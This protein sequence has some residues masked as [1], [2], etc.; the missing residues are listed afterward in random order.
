MP[1]PATG[2][3]AP[4][5]PTA[6]C[7]RPVH[8]GLEPF[9]DTL[10]SGVLE[11]ATALAA[12]RGTCPL[13]EL[14]AAGRID[15][16]AA[17]RRI[18]DHCG[19]PFRE[20]TAERALLARGT[21]PD[22]NARVL[23]CLSADGRDVATLH[24]APDARG[25]ERLADGVAGRPVAIA[26]PRALREAIAAARSANALREAVHGLGTRAP[27][28]S[29][30][31]TATGMQGWLAATLLWGA[32]AVLLWQP[33]TALTALNALMSALFAGCLAV[34]I[35][36]AIRARR[37]R[38]ASLTATEARELPIYS[39]L[40][41]LHREAA[42]VPQL[43]AHLDRLRWPRTKLDICLVCEADDAET[44][45][46]I[47]RQGLPPHMRVVRVPPGGPRTKPKALNY[48]ADLTRGELL[49]L[50]DAEDRPHP[51]QLLEAHAAFRDGAAD[52]ACLQAPLQIDNGHASPLA[53]GFALEYAALFRGLLPW[54]AARRLPVPLGGTSNHFKRAALDDVGGWDPFNVTEDA[55]LG[56]RLS[57][58]GYRT[59]V[60]TRPTLEAAPE[61]FGVWLPQRTRWL[62]GWMQTW[63]VHM[64]DA[65]GLLRAV[66]PLGFLVVQL[67]TIGTMASVLLHPFL[68]LA[69]GITAAT[70]VGGIEV[71]RLGA[72]LLALDVACAVAGHLVF[73]GLARSVL[74]RRE[75]WLLR[76]WVVNVPLYW[77]ALGVAGWRALWQLVREPHRW[78][79]TPH[80][81]SDP[82]PS[83][84]P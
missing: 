27:L 75:R 9:R 79:K 37:P 54:L 33:G 24:V 61:T 25:V 46:A 2:G 32:L 44:L 53:R 77:L 19:L 72:A 59:G 34:R 49:V 45:R 30:E 56:L 35:A 84:L 58:A 23:R 81:P 68:L 12:R 78:E 50:Y 48:A 73:V 41:A 62:K 3:N 10:P 13:A 57:A 76:G 71:T 11:D 28:A 1:R 39:V 67:V 43:V 66:G 38:Y 80:M 8:P 4:A 29:A 47:E 16:A 51:Y 40:V 14:I 74:H 31:R 20:P 18:A 21:P 69:L 36:A 82:S 6:P 55:D 83:S 26:T 63:M 42:V 15:E 17:Y 52:L 65:R 7:V 70:L 22:P 5:S 60:L 64:R